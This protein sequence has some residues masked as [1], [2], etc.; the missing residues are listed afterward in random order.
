MKTIIASVPFRFI[1]FFLIN[2]LFVT[3]ASAAGLSEETVND[4]LA[5]EPFSFIL[6]EFGFIIA[7]ALLAHMF[8][9]HFQMPRMLGELLI[10]IVI[11]NLLYWLDLS[12]VFYI[13]MHL[14]DATEIFKSVWTSDLPIAETISGIYI[15]DEQETVD[16]V[17]RMTAIF[18]STQSPAFILLGVGL[19]LFSNFGIFFLLFKLG[20]ETKP[21]NIIKTAEPLAYLISVTGTLLPFILGLAASYWL[22]PDISTAQHIF[23]AAALCPTS[24]ALTT[25]LFSKIERVDTRE[26]RLAIQAAY[27]DDIFN[28]FFLAIISNIVI[29]QILNPAD[30]LAFFFYSTLVSVLIIVSGKQIVKIIPK[31]YLLNETQTLIVLPMIIVFFVSWLADLLSIGMIS[32]A[33]MAGMI[34]NNIQ[35]NRDMI[36][37]MIDSLEKIFAPIFFIFVG[38]QVNLE[39]FSNANI[40][41]L[42][43]V[44]FT[45]AVAG[46]VLAGYLTQ[47]KIHYLAVGL[48]LVPRGEAVLIFISTGKIIGIINDSIFSVIV[49]IVLFS[50]L[51]TPWAIKK[52]CTAKCLEKSFALKTQ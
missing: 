44:L 50:Y 36:K 38:M 23:I 22:L 51:I 27:I 28:V 18:T 49:M 34:M 16:F 26:A 46:K 14:G 33:F 20:L 43:L 31:Y 52:F 25:H 10:G 42:T 30:I 47:Q 24:A 8:S 21:E 29:A 15:S 6:L 12:P 3:S 9:R 7:L 41:L 5:S 40:V 37:N 35:G 2:L 45:T 4:F 39:L 48:G 1:S 13:L 11:G 17:T 32:S 19:W